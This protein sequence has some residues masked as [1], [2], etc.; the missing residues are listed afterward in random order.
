MPITFVLGVSSLIYLILVG[1]PL[2]ILSQCMA[3]TFDSFVMLAIPLFIL[4]GML[5]NTGGITKRLFDF[6]NILVRHIPGGLAQ[7][8]IVA[9]MIFAGMSGSATADA[10]GL[11]QVEVKAMHDKG[12]PDDFTAAITA[13]SACLGPII[14]PSISMV[15]YGALSCTSVGALFVGGIIPGIIAG[16]G[17]M[18]MVYIIS[19][20]RKFSYDD[21]IA[22]ASEIIQAFWKALPPLLTPLI[23]LGGILSGIFTPT[24][25]A[26]VASLYAFILGFFIYKE[27]NFKQ[28]F[29]IL[30]NVGKLTACV[31]VIVCTARIFGWA[32]TQQRIPQQLAD[33]LISGLGNKYLILIALNLFLLFL[34]CFIENTAIEIVMIPIMVPILN[35]AGISILQF[36]IVMAINMQIALITPP[37]G[38]SLYVVCKIANSK[39][40]NVVKEIIPFLIVLIIV[41]LLVTYVPPISLLLPNLILR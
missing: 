6:A 23:I 39:F 8:N 27:L 1:Q 22:S 29:K 41:L 31:M 24:E 34:G 7:V 37:M 15:I 36:G 38:M 14:P 32:L 33:L 17:L 2:E 26:G 9:S 3:L 19:K 21:K 4:A 35:A 18:I 10:A 12:F 25:A 40:E 13:A 11:G 28:V 16:L 20:K 5:M 30:Y